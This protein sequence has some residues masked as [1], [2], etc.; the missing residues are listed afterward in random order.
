MFMLYGKWTASYSLEVCVL[1]GKSEALQSYVK[2]LSYEA[3]LYVKL[4]L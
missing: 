1:N 3:K 2:Q 4:C